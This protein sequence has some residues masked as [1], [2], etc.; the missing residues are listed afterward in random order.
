MQV[1]TEVVPTRSELNNL[2]EAS[3]QTWTAEWSDPNPYSTRFFSADDMQV[4]DMG[5]LWLWESGS[6]EEDM[7]N[8]SG[9]EYHI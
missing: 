7:S 1:R 9:I 8:W 6:H 3:Q 5:Q 2:Q 4:A